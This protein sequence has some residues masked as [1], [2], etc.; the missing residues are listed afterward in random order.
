MNE[1]INMKGDCS[2]LINLKE[3]ENLVFS[4]SFIK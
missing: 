4:N 3:S 2:S 1:S